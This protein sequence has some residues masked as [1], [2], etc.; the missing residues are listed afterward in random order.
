[1]GTLKTDSQ[2]LRAGCVGLGLT[3]VKS[4]SQGKMNCVELLID[5]TLCKDGFTRACYMRGGPS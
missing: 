5:Y 2:V 1:M 3:I 4:Y